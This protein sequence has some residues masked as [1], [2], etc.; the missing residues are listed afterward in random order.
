[1]DSAHI[2]YIEIDFFCAMY[3]CAM[4]V[5]IFKTRQSSR[6]DKAFFTGTVSIG[7]IL[8]TDIASSVLVGHPGTV[9]HILLYIINA[10][11]FIFTGIA[12]YA[13]LLY[14]DYALTDDVKA[15]DDRRI[16]YNVPCALLTVLTLASL[17]F[18]FIFYIDEMNC[19]QRGDLHV[20]QQL[21]TILYFVVALIFSIVSLIT[22]KN[23]L[24][25]YVCITMLGFTTIPLVGMVLQVIFPDA[26]IIWPMA[27][28]GLFIV[29]ANLQNAQIAMDALTGLNNRSRLIKYIKERCDKYNPKEVLLC[30]VFDIDNFKSI[31]DRYGHS[32]GD[33]AICQVASIVKKTVSSL[34]GS[35]FIARYTGNGFVVVSLANRD[36][37]DQ[38]ITCFDKY[39]EE[40]N[41]SKTNKY[42]LLVSQGHSKF[43]Q[44]EMTADDFLKAAD[45][46]M[47]KNK[48]EMKSHRQKMSVEDVVF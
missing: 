41:D 12:A 20:A 16:M 37:S 8:I 11:Y 31:N 6:Q 23:V 34:D 26:A 5:N 25:H 29:F 40:L 10:T 21:I 38:I 13:C 3:I 36:L 2:M 4:L 15:V 32:E 48:A 22:T 24:K 28:F 39:L 17:R 14:V 45:D 42:Q 7:L 1:M 47:Y 19:Y 9:I 44:Y 43:E 35:H 46:D 33:V 18:H 30:T 27:S